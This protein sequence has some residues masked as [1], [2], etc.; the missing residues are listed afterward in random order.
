MLDSQT[1][2]DY[3]F[4]GI[5]VQI[6]LAECNDGAWIY[7]YRLIEKGK[8]RGGGTGVDPDASTLDEALIMV[9]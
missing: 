8:N 6:K 9:I 1:L 2:P 5:T 3:L 4:H 7:R